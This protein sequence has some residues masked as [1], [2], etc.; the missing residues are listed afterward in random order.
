V[1]FASLGQIL[2]HVIRRGVLRDHG[3]KAE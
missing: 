1:A 3:V 2:R